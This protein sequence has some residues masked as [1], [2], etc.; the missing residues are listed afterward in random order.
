MRT[1]VGHTVYRIT[2]KTLVLLLLC[3]PPASALML[4]S[5][6][7]ALALAFPGIAVERRT[8]YLTPEQVK[9]AQEAGR[10][11]V[12][13][14]VWT[15]YVGIS[16]KGVEGYA[17]FD[18]HV[19]RTMPETFMAVVEPDGRLR[20]VELLAFLE[21]DDYLPGARWLDQFAGRRLDADLLVRRGIRNITG[22][23]LTAQ[24]LTDGVRRVLAVHSVLHGTEKVK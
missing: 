7:Q 3:A 20:F 15:Y 11:K 12:A 13:A 14:R 22:A 16:S 6:K 10:V 17:Y 19:V 18:T 2:L 4:L 8:A 23:T 24:A 5:Q 9:R 21:P 1:I